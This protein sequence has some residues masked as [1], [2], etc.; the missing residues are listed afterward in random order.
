MNS[1]EAGG[2]PAVM[3]WGAGLAVAAKPNGMPVAPDRTGDP[4]LLSWLRR[5]TGCASLELVNRIDRPV[6]G[7]VLAAFPPT[8]QLLNEDLRERR[9]RKLYRA[10]VEGRPSAADAPL[11]LTHSLGRDGGRRR[12]VLN[13]TGTDRSTEARLSVRMLQQGE[14]YSLVEVE[15]EGGAF[16][17][18]RA[19]L[20][21]WGHP[22]KG[23]VK[24]GARRAERGEAGIAR[25]IAL[26]AHHLELTHPA[27]AQ[28]IA[29][30]APRPVGRLWQLFWPEDHPTA[31]PRP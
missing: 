14:R 20:A 3:H 9:V 6:S 29:I 25:S 21:A 1:I 2:G 28:V 13:A 12:A 26:H 10:I 4:D 8:L 19:Q 18:I 23:D 22:I 31:D 17:Q 7:L 16:H 24:Y 30:T 11:W 27:T 5:T 15:P